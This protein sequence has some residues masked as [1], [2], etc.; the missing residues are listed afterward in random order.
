MKEEKGGL[1]VEESKKLLIDDPHP[2][3]AQMVGNP[4][5]F[6]Y[7]RRP[8]WTSL[9]L[10]SGLQLLRICFFSLLLTSTALS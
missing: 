10:V 4:V 9:I 2:G 7:L 5:S 1:G 3:E 6:I 8:P